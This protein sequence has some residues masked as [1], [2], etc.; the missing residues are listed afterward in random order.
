M[1]ISVLTLG[2]KVN[3]YESGAIAKHLSEI[4]HETHETLL[5]ADI[6]IINTCAVTHDAE[7]KSRQLITKC[8]KQNKDGKVI[9]MGCATQN[10]TAQ[11]ETKHNVVFMLGNAKKDMA[12]SEVEKIQNQMNEEKSLDAQK[13]EETFD[14]PKEYEN[15]FES[16]THKTRAFIKVQDGCNNFC[17]YCIIPYLRGRSRS[18]SVQ[19]VSSEV[20]NLKDVFEVVLVGIDLSDFEGGLAN[21]AL[22]VNRH[23]IR[24]RFGS[25]EASVITPELLSALKSCENFCPQFHLSL[26]AGEDET[27]KAMNRKY[28]TVEYFEKVQLIREYFENSAITTDIIVGF[29]TESKGQFEKSMDFA[30]CAEFA[31]IHVFPYSVRSGTLASK[32]YEDLPAEFKNERK[33]KMLEVKKHLQKTYLESHIGKEVEILLEE[34]DGE[35]LA[36]HSREFIKCYTK[37]GTPN[38]IVKATVEKIY[39]DGAIC[40]IK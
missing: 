36:G 37:G 8:L 14:L 30:K 18:R 6:Y 21:L 7:K 38:T 28:T 29:P 23:G 27:L 1:K 34:A 4:G 2:C 25:I 35:Y 9:V 10:K 26:Q 33:D 16:S 40:T 19:S 11:F 20:A 39:K 15:S 5:P 17:S 31:D 3:Q 13:V 12:I 22:E 24:F 32:K